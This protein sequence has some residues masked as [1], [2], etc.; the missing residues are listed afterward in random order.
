[1]R[2]RSKPCKAITKTMCLQGFAYGSDKLWLPFP[3]QELP[4][5]DMQGTRDSTATQDGTFK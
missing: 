2:Q 3:E 4:E 5:D 1:M